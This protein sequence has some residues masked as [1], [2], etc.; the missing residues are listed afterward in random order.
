MWK[1]LGPDAGGFFEVGML[2]VP[3]LI[4]LA[5]LKKLVSMGDCHYENTGTHRPTIGPK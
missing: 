2:N 4:R 5:Y 3:F 1:T